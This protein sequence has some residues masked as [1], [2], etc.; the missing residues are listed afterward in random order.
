MVLKSFIFP[1][2]AEYVSYIAKSLCGSCLQVALVAL[3]V[4]DAVPRCPLVLSMLQL[5][6]SFRRHQLWERMFSS[7]LDASQSDDLRVGATGR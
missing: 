7:V 3:Q 5:W 6:L 1:C 4:G 2:R